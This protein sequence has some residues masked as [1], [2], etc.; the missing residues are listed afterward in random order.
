MASSECKFK[1]I[2]VCNRGEIALRIIRSLRSLK[3]EAHAIYSICD[4][5]A[6]HV[7]AADK[8]HALS[9]DQ[10][11][12]SYMNIEKIIRIAKAAGIDAVHP[13]YGFLSENA[14]FAE[15]VIKAGMEFIGPRPQQ[16]LLLADKVNAKKLAAKLKI[17]TLESLEIN[18]AAPDLK[19]L[20]T[21][22]NRKGLPLLIKAA[23]GGGGRGMRI[24]RKFKDMQSSITSAARESLSVFNSDSIYIEPY[25][26]NARHIEVQV[27]GDKY[28]NCSH[29]WDRDCS[30]QRNHQKVIEEA[31]APNI[32][33]KVRRDIHQAALKL[34]RAVNYENLG[35]VEFLLDKNNKFY[36]L[37]V[38]SR[39]QVEHPVSE[40]I[41]GLDFIKLQIDVASGKKLKNIIPKN[42]QPKGHSIQARICSES[43]EN[44][45][46]P[47]SGKIIS[48]EFPQNKHIRIDY[49]YQS[50]DIIPPVYDS[51]VAKLIVHKKNRQEAIQEITQALQQTKLFGPPSNLPFLSCL[52][53]S[54]AFNKTAADT[55]YIKRFLN[56]L[57]WES[58]YYI[59]ASVFHIIDMNNKFPLSPDIWSKKNSWNMLGEKQPLIKKFLI[60][61]CINVTSIVSIEE[62]GRYLIYSKNNKK[63][64]ILEALKLINKKCTYTL[65]GSNYELEVFYEKDFAYLQTALGSIKIKSDNLAAS[66]DTKSVFSKQLKAQL[67]GKIIKIW[68]KEGSLV[69]RGQPL[70]AIESM[71]ME[72]TIRAQNDCKI[73]KVHVKEAE[74][75]SQ[76][77]LLLSMQQD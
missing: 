4:S 37:E 14:V 39:L 18:S 27:I 56:S 8:A 7:K 44:D 53:K 20:K 72:H 25:L 71:K 59:F 26:E 21:F 35:T 5:G 74:L 52:F 77:Q 46:K 60:N 41:C 57:S 40:E 64:I 11:A 54:A 19:A 32:P 51:I 45:F 47:N 16:I 49:G 9:S 63:A 13:G 38:N 33:D 29:L 55:L 31:P 48:L 36:F 68:G 50:N 3:I 28:G 58:V 42:L 70:L 24:V 1:K 23:S 76:D 61:D 6:L 67:P 66:T 22:A 62:Q 43:P 65:D 69:K 75:V 34:A 30:L 2:L 73:G 17:R 15:K 12:L 10:A